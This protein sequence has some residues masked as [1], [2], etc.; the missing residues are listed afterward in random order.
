[1][2][3]RITGSG[4][5]IAMIILIALRIP[6]FAFCECRENLVLNKESCCPTSP[7]AQASE[8]DCCHLE[9][10]PAESRPCSD[11]IVIL[12]IDPGHYTWSSDGFQAKP[13]WE[14]P[15]AIQAGLQDQLLLPSVALPAAS[16]RGSPPPCALPDFLLGQVL[17]L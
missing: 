7:A 8:V 4:F 9:E 17:R 14:S 13:A 5:T 3:R 12:S 11:C 2:F 1:M 15:T 16:I 6:A 10:I